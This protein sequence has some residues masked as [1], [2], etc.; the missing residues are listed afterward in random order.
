ML[1]GGDVIT[2]LPD[3]PRVTAVAVRGG[4]ILAIG[5]SKEGRLLAVVH[6]QRGERDRLI[7]ARLATQ[8]EAK[9]YTKT[10]G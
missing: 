2:N 9:L 7:S 6:V 3:R 5:L 10:E 4:R 8:T 1:V